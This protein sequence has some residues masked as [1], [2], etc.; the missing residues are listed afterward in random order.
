[1][2]GR[3]VEGKDGFKSKARVNSRTVE[4]SLGSINGSYI[5]GNGS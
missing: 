5:A 3:N 1:M 2:Q 4:V